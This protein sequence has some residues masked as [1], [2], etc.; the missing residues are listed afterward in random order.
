MVKIA[1]RFLPFSAICAAQSAAQMA[2]LNSRNVTWN[3][4]SKFLADSTAR[5]EFLPRKISSQTLYS[6]EFPM[7]QS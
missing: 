7:I 6:S 5:L 2:L 3:L 1:K 4:G